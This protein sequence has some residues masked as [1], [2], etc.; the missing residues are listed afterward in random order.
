MEKRIGGWEGV[1]FAIDSE[2]SFIQKNVNP[3]AQAQSRV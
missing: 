1:I 2:L 3:V